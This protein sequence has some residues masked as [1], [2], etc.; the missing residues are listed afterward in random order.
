M[1]GSDGLELHAVALALFEQRKK[2]TIVLW[3]GTGKPHFAN[4]RSNS[5][6][7]KYYLNGALLSRLAYPMETAEMSEEELQAMTESPLACQ[8]GYLEWLL[9]NCEQL[10]N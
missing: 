6:G 2:S 7:A 5:A 1:L 8:W 9:R 3:E 4:H 10:K